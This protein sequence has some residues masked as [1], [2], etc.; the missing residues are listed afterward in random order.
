M[1]SF[2]H[3]LLLF[4]A[5]AFAIAV[6]PAFS[7]V[8]WDERYSPDP[9]VCWGE[10]INKAGGCVDEIYASEAKKKVSLSFGCCQA[11]QGMDR[12]CKNWIFNHGRLTPEFGNQIKVFCSTLSVTLPP[13]YRVYY[14]QHRIPGHGGRRRGD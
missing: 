1:G 3:H 10:V 7:V 4:T 6:A 14:P 11:I 5:M 13:A 12:R 8:G 2:H 9:E